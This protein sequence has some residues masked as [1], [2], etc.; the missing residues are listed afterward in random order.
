L[1]SLAIKGTLKT[2]Y[3]ADFVV[4]NDLPFDNPKAIWNSRVLQTIV[5]G[6]VV[7]DSLH[8]D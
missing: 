7:Y 8:K 5:N 1:W 3:L 4:L 2:G 6:Q